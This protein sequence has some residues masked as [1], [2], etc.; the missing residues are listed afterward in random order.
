MVTIRPAKPEDDAALFAIDTATWLP[1]NSPAVRSDDV[2]TFFGDR[3][4][5]ADVLVAE[6]A[7]EVVGYA[8]LRNP[9]QMPAHVHVWEINGLAVDSAASGKGVGGA[10]VEAAFSEAARRGARKVS[11]RV[12]GPNTVARK[13]YARC[14]FHEE[15]VLRDEFLLD[16]RFVDD[17]LM[18]RFVE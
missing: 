10:L 8:A 4:D 13:L 14:G 7:G 17:V 9:T 2:T 16:G 6:L 15:G 12:L 3:I 18:A 11:L 1:T 5:P